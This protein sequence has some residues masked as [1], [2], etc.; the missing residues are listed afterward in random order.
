MARSMTAGPLPS[1][2]VARLLR[3]YEQLAEE[4]AEVNAHLV[5]LAPAWAEL[6]E[7]P[8]RAQPGARGLTG[9]G[10]LVLVLLC[11]GSRRQP[12]DPSGDGHG[13]DPLGSVCRSGR[14]HG[15]CRSVCASRVAAACTHQVLKPGLGTGHSTSVPELRPC[16]G[17]R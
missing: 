13:R 6:R 9:N 3:S 7:G 16:E 11:G 15:E 5:K 14:T 8:E 10:I 4:Q 1:D 17:A 12:V 2:Q